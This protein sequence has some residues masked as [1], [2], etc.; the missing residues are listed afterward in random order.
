MS[1]ECM[2]SMK[3]QL[4]DI[5]MQQSGNHFVL[6]NE[7]IFL[8]NFQGGYPHLT[9]HMNVNDI[10]KYALKCGFNKKQVMVM[11]KIAKDGGAYIRRS[12]RYNSSDNV[13]LEELFHA[14]R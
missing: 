13:L 12:W 6:F 1:T 10:L 11:H 4:E 7:A 14:V 8:P 5:F 9:G 3:N 2:R